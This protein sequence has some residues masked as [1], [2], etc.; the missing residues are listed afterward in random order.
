MNPE[1]RTR[2]KVLRLVA[3][4]H[5]R[6]YQR[7]RIAPGLSP[8]GHWRCVITPASNILRSHGA[9]VADPSR[10]CALY[11]SPMGARYFGWED[12]T[13]ATPSRLADLF[14][15]RFPEIAREGL[16]SDWL[17]AGWYVEMLHLTYPSAFPVAF[18]EYV[19]ADRFLPTIDGASGGKE[20]PL[21]PAGEAP[22]ATASSEPGV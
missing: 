21:P 8:S 13:R 5:L 1:H 17:Y 4:L 15:A 12:A 18:G 22:E 20:I 7:L 16:G 2:R 6:G 14:I 19:Q 9:S 10:R 3:E 11:T